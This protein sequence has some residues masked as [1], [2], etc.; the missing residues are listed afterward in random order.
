MTRLNASRRSTRHA[1]FEALESREM[2]SVSPEW[3]DTLSAP[4][5]N[6]LAYAAAHQDGGVSV[7]GRFDGTVDFDPGPGKTELTSPG[8]LNDG[9]PDIVVA[10][11]AT[12]GNFLWARWIGDN[13]P[14]H[15]HIDTG[16]ATDR[17]GNTYVLGIFQGSVQLGSQTL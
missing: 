10:R 14:L 17:A 3:L 12:N 13:D 16:V 15:L 4:A 8:P 1:R 9:N 7:T 11:Y 6:V 5:L 2:L